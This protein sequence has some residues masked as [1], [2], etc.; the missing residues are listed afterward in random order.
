[1]SLFLRSSPQVRP[2]SARRDYR[3]TVGPIY[4]L[5]ARDVAIY[6]TTRDRVQSRTDIGMHS[7]H[8]EYTAAKSV[9]GA[10]RGI[11]LIPSNLNG[12]PKGLRHS[13]SRTTVDNV[14][15]PFES[16]P[17]TKRYPPSVVRF[18]G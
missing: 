5:A 3:E 7:Y 6:I 10:H 11:H 8:A 9:S 13:V 17:L 4:D 16:E 18:R 1:M 2:R 15:S 12:G 14:G